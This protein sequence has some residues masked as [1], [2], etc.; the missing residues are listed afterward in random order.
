[1]AVRV[2]LDDRAQL[3]ARADQ[4][5]HRRQVSGQGILVDLRPDAARQRRQ[6][7]GGK[8]FVD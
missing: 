6:P 8:A 4:L 3:D 5:A 1:M 7:G 2:G